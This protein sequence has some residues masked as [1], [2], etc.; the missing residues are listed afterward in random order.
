MEELLSEIKYAS[1]KLIKE[2]N[3]ESIDI[4]VDEDVSENKRV[5]VS[6]DF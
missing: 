6:I 2:Y 1:E 5:R 4:Y 3:V